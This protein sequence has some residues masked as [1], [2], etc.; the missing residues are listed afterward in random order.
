MKGW[1]SNE[2]EMSTTAETAAKEHAQYIVT[3]NPGDFRRV[4]LGE[5]PQIRE[6]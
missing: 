2:R 6:P 3:L 4:V 5:T 1:E